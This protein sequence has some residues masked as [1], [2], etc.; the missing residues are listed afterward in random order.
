MFEAIGS[1]TVVAGEEIGQA[2]ALKL[3][4]N[5]WI[6]LLTAGIAQSL[7]LAEALGVDPA[8]FLEAIKGGAV[9][10]P[11]AQLKGAAMLAGDYATSFAVDGVRKDTGLMVEAARGAAF[12]VDLLSAVLTRFDQAAE[13]GHGADDMAAVRSAFPG[14]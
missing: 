6:G 8:L 10:A 7:A 13:L 4:C 9:D 1:R 5:A 12:P 3:A 14:S 2:S 11:Y